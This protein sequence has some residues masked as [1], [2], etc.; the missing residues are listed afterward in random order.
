MYANGTG[1]KSIFSGFFVLTPSLQVVK[2]S[3]G[4]FLECCVTR[5]TMWRHCPKKGSG[6]R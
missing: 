1:A 5:R 3:A 6:K 2:Q 4:I